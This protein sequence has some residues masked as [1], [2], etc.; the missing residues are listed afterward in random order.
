MALHFFFRSQY[1][2]RCYILLLYI[3]IVHVVRKTA[4]IFLNYKDEERRRVTHTQR[5]KRTPQMTHPSSGI[6]FGWKTFSLLAGVREVKLSYKNAQC[7]WDIFIRQFYMLASAAHS[8]IYFFSFPAH[9][10]SLY[11]KKMVYIQNVLI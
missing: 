4:D 8:F 6:M 11:K 1:F 5:R 7:T 2:Q 9:N 3:Y 10:C